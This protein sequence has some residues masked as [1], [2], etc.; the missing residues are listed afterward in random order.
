[1]KYICILTAVI[2]FL[3]AGCSS[4]PD[5]PTTPPAAQTEPE[6][7]V[8]QDS[9]AQASEAQDAEQPQMFEESAAD[10]AEEQSADQPILLAQAD[11]NAPARDWQFEQ[12]KHYFRF[13]STQPVV[14]G[15]DKIE[16]AE[17]FWYGCGHCYD[18]EPHINKWAENKPENV[19]FVRIPATWNPLLKLHAQL[20]YVEEVLVKNGKLAEPEAFRS[21]VFA[22][23]H[24]R[25][26]RLTS[27]AAIQ[28]L[29]ER[30]GVSADDFSDTWKSFEVASK[31]NKAQDLAVRYGISGVPA[32]VVNGKYRTGASA[33][34]RGYPA[35]LEVVDE[36]IAREST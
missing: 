16:V 2:S 23:Y 26:N 30:H 13:Q 24:Q 17:I 20:Y 19:R 36:L 18:F 32:V 21:A 22:E 28:S 29:F 25:G 10:P 9:E 35:V 31:L 12:G 27:E 8:Q 11:T 4:E 7:T 3:L 5:T 33:D 1:M 15:P 14:G 6:P 34:V